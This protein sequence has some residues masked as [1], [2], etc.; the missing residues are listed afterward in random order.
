MS[1]VRFFDWLATTQGSV[2]L[3]HSLYLYLMVSI[4]HV[5]TLA[6]FVG[7]AAEVTPIR[8]ID[9]IAVGAGRRGPVTERVQRAFF[10]IVTGE[11][12]DRHRWLT[13]VFP[14]QAR[15]TSADMDRE[16]RQSAPG[17]PADERVTHA[18]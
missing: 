13:P 12:A 6:F 18:R 4:V 14:Q 1:L 7:T 5:V 10:E 8:S 15:P 11:A 9:R 17:A 2:A 3:H 16:S